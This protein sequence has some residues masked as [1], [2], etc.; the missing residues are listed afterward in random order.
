M[1]SIFVLCAAFAVKDIGG[2]KY[3]VEGIFPNNLIRRAQ[4]FCK[5][6]N[7]GV[8]DERIESAAAA[9]YNPSLL[10]NCD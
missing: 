4:E 2:G 8:A 9:I 6:Q 5:K 1:R 3:Y 7:K 10:F